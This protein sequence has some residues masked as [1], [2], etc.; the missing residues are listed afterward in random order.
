MLSRAIGVRTIAAMNSRIAALGLGLFTAACGSFV[1]PTG[2]AEIQRAELTSSGSDL[3]LGIDVANGTEAPIYVYDS[4]RSVAREATLDRTTLR[5]RDVAW[6]N[7]G[8]SADCHLL[9]PS[10]RRIEPL[11]V[12][13]LDLAV[14][15]AWTSGTG[16]IFPSTISTGEPPAVPAST[17][18]LALEFAW[19]DA[20]FSTGKSLCS[21]DLASALIAI[22][23]GVMTTSIRQP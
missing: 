20:P 6:T 15:A 7:T 19:S 8:S 13:H 11:S 17:H 5:F 21:A 3:L 22:Q 12:M 2:R 16:I 9:L 10:Y 23:K 14:P 18:E 1:A 4:V